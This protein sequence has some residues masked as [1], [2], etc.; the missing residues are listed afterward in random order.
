MPLTRLR[1]G[2]LFTILVPIAIASTLTRAAE[3]T[4][5]AGR[6]VSL[7]DHI[8]RVMAAEPAA[9][10]LV[11]VLAPDRLIGWAQPP[12]GHLL[13][14]RYARLPVVGQLT[15]SN[16]TATAQTVSQLHPDVTP[17]R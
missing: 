16:P 9:E 10:V 2:A 5:S 11:F 15:G 12:Q 4:D 3:F 13:S 17:A 6:L 14:A 8:G 1:F 7:P